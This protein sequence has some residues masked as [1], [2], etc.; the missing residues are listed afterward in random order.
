MDHLFLEPKYATLERVPMHRK[1]AEENIP[2]HRK[3]GRFAYVR[4]YPSQTSESRPTVPSQNDLG[5]WGHGG[6]P[7]PATGMGSPQH[8]QSSRSSHNNTGRGSLRDSHGQSR[9]HGH[10][11]SDW[12]S[13]NHHSSHTH[14]HGHSQRHSSHCKI[15]V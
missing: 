6:P 11:H 8:T 7:T 9:S 12:H 13:E 1:T 15:M 14:S 5:G 3:F 10:S 2:T 4:V